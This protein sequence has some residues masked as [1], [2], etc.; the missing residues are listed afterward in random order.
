MIEHREKGRINFMGKPSITVRLWNLLEESRIASGELRPVECEALVDTGATFVVLPQV[1]AEQLSLP[2][3]GNRRVRYADGHTSEKALVG[4]LIVQV[5]GRTAQCRAIVEPNGGQVL[6][7]Q[8]ALE[9]LDLY[10]DCQGR[11]LVPRPESPDMPM[12]EAYFL[13]P[14]LGAFG[15]A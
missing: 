12:A 10:V 11:R 1:L 5:D 9:D 8:L 13:R 14:A 7:G 3:A 15:R 2:F 6:I 4:A